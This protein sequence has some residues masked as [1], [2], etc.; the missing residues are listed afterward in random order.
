MVDK[1]QGQGRGQPLSCSSVVAPSP[2]GRKC[3]E[4]ATSFHRPPSPVLTPGELV[5]QWEGPQS[6][7]GTA[8][9]SSQSPKAT[10]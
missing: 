1:A 7:R 9:G 3:G 2:V 8:G 6:L 4:L 10:T 5:L